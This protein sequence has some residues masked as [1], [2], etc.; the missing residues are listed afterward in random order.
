VA[1]RRPV[2]D[3]FADAEGRTVG[4]LVG[5]DRRVLSIRHGDE[6]VAIIVSDVALEEDPSSWRSCTPRRLPELKAS[7]ERLVAVAG[8]E[9][10]RLERNLHDGAQ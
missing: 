4:L 7:R 9:R 1:Y 3:G 10:R 2:D 6:D 5:D 8:A